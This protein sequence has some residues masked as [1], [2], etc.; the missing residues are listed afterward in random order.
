MRLRELRAGT[1]SPT[2]WLPFART[3]LGEHDE[4]FALLRE[5]LAANPR[6]RADLAKDYQWWFR[7]LRTDPR[8]QQLVAGAR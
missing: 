6:H 7:D 1:T 2:A 3:V 5:Y 4:A 8:C